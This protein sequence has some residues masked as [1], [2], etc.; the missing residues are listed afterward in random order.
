MNVKC[1][2]FEHLKEAIIFA[3]E[4]SKSEDIILFSPG[5][6]SFDE[7]T[8]YA[9]RGKYFDDLVRDYYDK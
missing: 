3:L 8:S 6:A 9:Q 5:C 1:I 4:T 2:R 7:F